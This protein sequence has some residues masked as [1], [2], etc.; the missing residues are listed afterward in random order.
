MKKTIKVLLADD[1]RIFL[2]GLRAILKKEKDIRIDAE[3]TSGDEVLQQLRLHEI[4]VV[5]LDIEMDGK[6]GIETAI[7][8]RALYPYIR[9]LMLTMH[10]DGERIDKSLSVPVDGYILKNKGADQLV[11]AILQLHNGRT[12]FNPEISEALV[13]FRRSKAKEKDVKLTPREWEVLHLIAKEYT[14]PLIAETLFIAQST[15]ETHRR[16]LIGKLGVKGTLGLVKWAVEN[17]DK[18]N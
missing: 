4:D 11:E 18:R 8:I 5:V 17:S 15:V 2:D 3:A 12:Y 9:I 10:A 16:N 7:E 13:R 1:H 6:N 14:T